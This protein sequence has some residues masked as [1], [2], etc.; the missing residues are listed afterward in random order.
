[1]ESFPLEPPPCMDG[2]NN[3]LCVQD[4]PD[5]NVLKLDPLNEGGMQGEV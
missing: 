4:G 3:V 2:V 1:M 5:P